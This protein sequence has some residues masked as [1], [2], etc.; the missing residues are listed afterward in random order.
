MSTLTNKA[1][2]NYILVSFNLLIKYINA[3]DKTKESNKYINYIE[4]ME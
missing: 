1:I 2:K 4:N 3:K